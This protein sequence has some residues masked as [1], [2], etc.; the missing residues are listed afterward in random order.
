VGTVESNHTTNQEK[1]MQTVTIERGAFGINNEAD[2]T[3]L[4]AAILSQMSDSV[5]CVEFADYVPSTRDEDGEETNPIMRR[6][7]AIWEGAW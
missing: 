3:A 7:V 4:R 5:D 6:V 2:E 1:I